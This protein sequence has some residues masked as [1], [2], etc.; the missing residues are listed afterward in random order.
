MRIVT[1][2]PCQSIPSWPLSGQSVV[3][4][5]LLSGQSVVCGKILTKSIL[6]LPGNPRMDLNFPPRVVCC[7]VK[8]CMLCCKTLLYKESKKTEGVG[9]ATTVQFQF[10][11]V[12]HDSH[13]R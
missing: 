8:L 3:P 10:Q 4:V 5:C 9:M 6:F 13:D 11:F 2:G 1:I 12:Y 7:I